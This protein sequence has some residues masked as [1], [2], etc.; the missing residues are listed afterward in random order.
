MSTT[1]KSDFGREYQQILFARRNTNFE[2]IKTLVR[3]HLEADRGTI[4]RDSEC[5][6]CVICFLSLDEIDSVSWSSNQVFESKDTCLLRFSLVSGKDTLSLRSEWKVEKPDRKIPTIKRVRRVVWNR[7]RTNWVRVDYFPWI[8]IEI[9]WKI[10]E[11]LEVRLLNPEQL[12]WTFHSCRCS[13]TLIGPRFEFQRSERDDAKRFQRGHWS[14]LGPGNEAKWYGQS[15]NQPDSY[16]SLLKCA[17]EPVLK[18]TMDLDINAG[19][20]RFCGQAL[21][22][23]I[24]WDW[25]SS[26]S[27]DFLSSWRSWDR[28][29]DRLDIWS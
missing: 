1:M 21:D 27:Q 11:D 5:I 7:W 15:A 20:S 18:W 26:W 23:K 10:Q 3:Y 16:Q 13:T 24:Y 14:F 4:I 25:T 12:E 29:S 17:T 28:N 6:C 2:E 9:L 22:T 8:H 19:S